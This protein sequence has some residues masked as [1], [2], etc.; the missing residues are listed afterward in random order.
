VHHLI[1]SNEEKTAREKNQEGCCQD[2]CDPSQ[3]GEEKKRQGHG[4]SDRSVYMLSW[5]NYGQYGMELT[6]LW[7]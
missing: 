1:R 2:C 3:T 7:N 5:E 4:S 6:S